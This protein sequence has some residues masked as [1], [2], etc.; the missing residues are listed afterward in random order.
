[1]KNWPE[2]KSIRNIQVFLGFANVYCY[3]IQG[4]SKIVAQ[5]TSIFRMSPTLTSA[6]QKLMDLVDEFGKDNCGENKTRKTF[7]STKQPTRADYPSSDYVSHVISNLVSN[8]ARNVSNY[9]NLDA[10]RAFD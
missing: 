7:A 10:K 8:S 9:L 4:F 2:A 1:M 5:L 3:F 6:T